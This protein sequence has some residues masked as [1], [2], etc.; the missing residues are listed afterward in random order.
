MKQVLL[1]LATLSLLA[2]ATTPPST[3]PAPVC[4]PGHSILSATLW[5]QHAAEYRA[6]A[7]QTYANARMALDRELASAAGG[8]PPAVI[9]D[10]D[11]TTL[12][13]TPFEAR[14]IRAGKTYDSA[15]WKAWTAEGGAPAVPGALEFLKYAQSRGVRP[16]YVTNR[17]LDEEAGTRRNLETLGFPLDPGIDTL[18][19]R[20]E[21]DWKSDKTARREHVAR[22]HRVLLLIGDDLN[23]FV[24]AREKSQAE[25]DELM[26]RTANEWGTRWFMLPNPMYGSW[27]RA[28]TGGTGTPCEQVQKK[29]EALRDR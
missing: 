11:E 8:L 1:T 16:F 22:T 6:V 21:N 25:R 15:S 20:G 17:D 18:L 23:D 9:L 12:D 3:A 4:N 29:V 14:V 5:T 2:C 7:L 27:E 13:N 19:Q 28:I 24:D 26:A 10:L